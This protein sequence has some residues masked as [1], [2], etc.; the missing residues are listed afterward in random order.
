M[1]TEQRKRYDHMRRTQPFTPARWA[2]DWAKSETH[3]ERERWEN[4]GVESDGERFAR[5]LGNGLRAVLRVHVESIFPMPNRDGS[6]DYGEYVEED[7]RGYD[8]DWDG[9]WPAP[10]GVRE[11]PLGLPYK[12]FRYSGPGWVQG[13]QGG[14]F[15]PDS[16]EETFASFRARGQSKSVAWDL[17]RES[18]EEQIASLFSAP[19]INAFVS[20]AIEHEGVELSRTDMGTHYCDDQDGQDYP[21]QMVAE[22][23]MLEEALGMAGETID[24]L[25]AVEL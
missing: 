5:D 17:T 25:K 10:V 3:G 2:L 20:I 24:K 18:V 19:L 7:R 21:F 16:I 1:T 6:T 9:Q 22:Y 4:D 14:Y 23:D 12:T 11:L 13:E 8:Y 15:I